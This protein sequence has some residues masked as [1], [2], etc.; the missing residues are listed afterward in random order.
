[1]V[2]ALSGC[3]VSKDECNKSA[4]KAMDTMEQASPGAVLTVALTGCSTCDH[5]SVQGRWSLPA[6][7]TTGYV[8]IQLSPH[9]LVRDTTVMVTP[10]TDTGVADNNFKNCGDVIDLD[11]YVTN[12]SNVTLEHMYIELTCPSLGE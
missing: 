6:T 5:S 9:C 4:K 1:M 10:D 2:V 7:A 8:E 12:R 11:G 3:I